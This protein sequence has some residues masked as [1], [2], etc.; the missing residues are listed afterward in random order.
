MIQPHPTCCLPPTSCVSCVTVY[1]SGVLLPTQGRASYL[2]FPALKE[3][4]SE[5]WFGGSEVYR[6]PIKSKQSL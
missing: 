3:L 2:W 1:R 4:V 5:V 6:R